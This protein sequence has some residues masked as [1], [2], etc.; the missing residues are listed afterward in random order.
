MSSA[1]T[2]DLRR[3]GAELARGLGSNKYVIESNGAQS[4]VTDEI[5]EL[6]VYVGYRQM[7]EVADHD[8]L[9]P[10]VCLRHLDDVVL[11]DQCGVGQRSRPQGGDGVAEV[12]G[13]RVDRRIVSA[14]G[15][16]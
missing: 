10:E 15:G 16:P 13:D 1:P 6:T 14:V 12:R 7:I 4:A 3:A 5:D 11:G 2:T 8:V 9:G